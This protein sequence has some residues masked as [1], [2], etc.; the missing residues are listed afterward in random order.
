[1]KRSVIVILMAFCAI[2]A[3]AA[4]YSAWKIKAEFIGGYIYQHSKTTI[5]P[6]IKGPTLGG[7]VAFEW[8]MKGNKPWHQAYNYPDVG[9]AL[10]VLDFGNPEVM[11]QMITPYTYISIPM[12]RSRWVDF[13]FRLGGGVGFCTKPC[14]VQGAIA[15]GK[16]I[17]DIAADY[18]FAIGGVAN[19]NVQVGANLEIKV[20]PNVS[21]TA[22]VGYNHFSSASLSQPNEGINL[23]MGSAGVKYVIPR[24]E[25]DTTRFDYQSTYKRWG[26]EV[27]VCGGAK[28]LYYKD[29]QYFGCAT[30][31]IAGYYRTCMWHRIGLGADLFYD[32]AYV[33]TGTYDENGNPVKVTDKTKFARTWTTSESV[34]NKIRFGMCLQNEL[35]IG[36][37]SA[38]IGFG[39][40][41]YD[42]VKNMEPYEKAKNGE[43]S[44][45]LF[46]KY[47][48]QKEDGWNYFRISA[49]YYITRN[50][51]V[52]L[53]FKTHLQKVEFIE[54]GIGYGW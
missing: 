19:V 37:F 27:I 21:I 20:H 28:K 45:G 11:G 43:V 31:N 7:E 52:N 23:F 4:D 9:I 16:G 39:I 30:L 13:N 49:K 50:L 40:Y 24:G 51:L 44:K 5:T 38:G 22:A 26:G 1:M 48:I 17:K 14:D 54:M 42:P 25:R 34:A 3:H 47:D 15:T 36:K 32:G 33:Q 29:S 35:V 2:C 10:Q 18:N 46:Y 8:S 6:L 12:V 53:S 41:L